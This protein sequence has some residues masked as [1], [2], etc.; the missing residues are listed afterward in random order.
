MSKSVF[1]T[2]TGTDVGKTYIA[3]LIVKTL[4]DNNINCGYYK[5][6]VSGV[7]DIQSSDPARVIDICGL[8]ESFEDIVS[9]SYEIPA[10]PHLS[11][12]IEGHEFNMDKVVNDYERLKN[13]YDYLVIEGAGGIFCPIYYDYNNHG[14]NPTKLILLEDIIKVLDLNVVMVSDLYLGAI[15]NVAL[16]INYMKQIGINLSGIIFNLKNIDDSNDER[17]YKNLIIQDNYEFIKNQFKTSIITTVKSFDTNLNL[18]IEGLL[19]H[20]K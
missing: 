10:S 6:V 5:P 19:Q 12:H 11:A 15:N 20:F 1:I 4:R 8:N 7:E 16:S 14:N 3:A 2:G 13:K 17:E 18:E 9:F